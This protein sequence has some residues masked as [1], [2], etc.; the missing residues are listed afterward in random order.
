V[1]R[2]RPCL[3][4]SREARWHSLRRVTLTRPAN[5]QNRPRHGSKLGVAM[6][7]CLRR[8]TR[9]VHMSIWT[10]APYRN[11][12]IFHLRMLLVSIVM[13][14]ATSTV[15]IAS[16][17]RWIGYCRHQLREQSAVSFMA[18]HPTMIMTQTR[19]AKLCC[20]KLSKG[21]KGP[22]HQVSL[23]NI[24]TA[25]ET[26]PPRTHITRASIKNSRTLRNI[27]YPF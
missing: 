4:R 3:K 2:E 23:G 7:D 26:W 18:K 11:K 15:C 21:S 25:I 8:P 27:P 9:N 24:M 12:S 6:C 16:L 13:S 1:C 22:V 20:F 10:Q 14:P 19:L 5:T 17:L